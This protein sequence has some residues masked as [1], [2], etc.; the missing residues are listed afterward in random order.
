MSEMTLFGESL[1]AA[2]KTYS[3]ERLQSL[4]TE[5]WGI[6][7]KRIG[8]NPKWMA[9]QK[10]GTLVKSGVN[11]ETI[12]EGAR[13]FAAQ[14]RGNGTKGRFVPMVTTWLNQRRWLSDPEP[15][16]LEERSFIDI[17]RDLRERARNNS[18][19]EGDDER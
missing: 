16:G 5:F 9:E 7:P 15:E 4:F 8:S 18:D 13:Q 6:F 14:C 3:A 2:T 10:F 11:P 12:I 1:P 17:A 19:D